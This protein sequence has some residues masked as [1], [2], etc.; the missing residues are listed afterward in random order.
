MIK[1]GEK[2]QKETTTESMQRTRDSRGKSRKR[3]GYQIG[4]GRREGAQKRV[5]TEENMKHHYIVDGI[6]WRL[7][8]EGNHRKNGK[9]GV[10]S[11]Q[12]SKG[13]G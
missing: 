8:P 2:R 9:E 13:R 1:E 12:G 11:S 4:E 7:L 5:P 10:P 6:I 3:V